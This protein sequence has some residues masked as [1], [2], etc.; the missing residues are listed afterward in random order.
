MISG[1]VPNVAE[2]QR[3][4]IHFTCAQE[5]KADVILIEN[6]TENSFWFHPGG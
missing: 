3:V 6:L 2:R 1:K 4:R 5:G